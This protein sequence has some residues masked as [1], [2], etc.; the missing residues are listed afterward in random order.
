MKKKALTLLELLIVIMVIGILAGAAVPLFRVSTEETRIAKARA[1]LEAIRR[2]ANILRA[3]TGYWPTY[4]FHGEGLV[5]NTGGG[6]DG[7]GCPPDPI[8]GWSGPYIDEWRKDPWGQSY[9]IYY[10]HPGEIRAES[11]GPDKIYGHSAGDDI[12]IVITMNRY[13]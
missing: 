9:H 12:T 8:P 4:G 5:D 11:Y 6:L 7:H 10:Y 13:Q 2:A 1:D 3:D